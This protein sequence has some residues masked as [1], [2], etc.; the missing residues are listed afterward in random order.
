MPASTNDKTIA[1]PAYFA[2]ADPVRTKMPAPMMAPIPRVIRFT[3]PSARLRLCSPVSDAS[4]ISLSRG[5]HFRRLDIEDCLFLTARLLTDL[6]I[7]S[8]P[9]EIHGNSE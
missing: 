5:L 6:R 4:F 8:G 2:A 9:Q 1:G 3:G 7:A